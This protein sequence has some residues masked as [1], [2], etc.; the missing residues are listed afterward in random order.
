MDVEKTMQFLL[1]WQAAFTAKLEAEREERIKSY[2]Q[3]RAER[4]RSYDQERAERIKSYETERAERIEAYQTERAERIKTYQQER[5]ARFE[6]DK[7]ERDQ[8]LDAED[9]RIEA[10]RKLSERLDVLTSATASLLLS[11][12]AQQAS[13]EEMR[14][15]WREMLDRFDRYLSG[16]SG[17]GKRAPRGKKRA[18]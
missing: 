15:R 5:A 11:A 9:E 14:G 17:N 18:G 8:R 6:A 10:D 2:D 1:E 16:Q 13:I 7:I 12:Q 3:E 4:I